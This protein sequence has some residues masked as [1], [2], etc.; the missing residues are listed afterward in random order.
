MCKSSF[1]AVA[2]GA[3][4]F[5][6]S[7]ALSADLQQTQAVRTSPE[8][9]SLTDSFNSSSIHMEL[10][11]SYARGDFIILQFPGEGVVDT[12][13]LP[14]QLYIE[15]QKEYNLPTTNFVFNVGD[16]RDHPCHTAVA[17]NPQYTHWHY[18]SQTTYPYLTI[19]ELCRGY[20]SE[21]EHFLRVWAAPDLLRAYKGLT[22][23]NIGSGYLAAED[24]TWVKFRITDFNGPSEL[25]TVGAPIDFGAVSLDAAKL[26]ALNASSYPV[27]T[28][29]RTN[30]D[31]Y[32]DVPGHVPDELDVHNEDRATLVTLQPQW[33]MKV[34]TEVF[35]RTVAVEEPYRRLFV[36]GASDSDADTDSA[37]FQLQ[38]AALDL[39]AVPQNVT[40]TLSGS[41][42]FSWLGLGAGEL[43]PGDLS[44]HVELPSSSCVW[45]EVTA[46]ALQWRCNAQ[47]ADGSD[48]LAS[49]LLSLRLNGELVVTHGDFTLTAVVGFGEEHTVDLDPLALGAWGL[50]GTAFTV[51]ALPYAVQQVSAQSGVGVDQILYLTNRK[52]FAAGDEIPKV[53]I[54]VTDA[55]GVRHEL[56]EALVGDLR[57]STGVTKLAGVVREA[58]FA[59]GL[60]HT[61]QRI[62]LTVVV[63]QEPDLLA[64]HS[65]YTI[66]N[67]RNWMPNDSQ[68]VSSP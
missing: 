48:L 59:K 6:S 21:T 22:L 29:S 64:L 28:V 49:Q 12:S 63:A 13:S 55:D 34:G 46:D 25:T 35:D 58:L 15:S 45:L 31:G 52:V 10:R 30:Y 54:E 14:A 9:L 33:Q 38:T 26:V 57:A 17:A 68:R 40:Y 23:D 2:L 39:A 18:E 50:N 5:F 53:Y 51:A 11:D 60:L 19:D 43:E 32:P 42:R 3:A 20:I 8:Y 65:A 66:G 56:A 37:E 1:A 41:D 24:L 7:M 47:L 67:D 4:A 16:D 61:S 27:M 62:A 36:V 44:P